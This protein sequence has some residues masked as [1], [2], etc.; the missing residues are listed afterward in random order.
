MIDNEYD[1]TKEE[2]LALPQADWKQP[3]TCHSFIIIPLDDLHDSG[4]RLMDVVALDKDMKP[5]I[6]RGGSADVL[7]FGGISPLRIKPVPWQ[8]D[9]LPKSGLLRFFA[10]GFT[11]KLGTALSS[12]EII[13][14][15][16]S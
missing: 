16:N 7:H 10:Y 1:L 13:D 14:E 3:I 12:L 2:F 4:F 9:C 8:C 5:F 11:F 6:R 15:Q